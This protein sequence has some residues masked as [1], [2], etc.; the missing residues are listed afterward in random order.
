MCR[1]F[2]YVGKNVILKKILWDPENSILKQSYKM[3]YTPDIDDNTRNH[4][5]NVDG[6]GISWY[7]KDNFPYLYKSLKTPWSDVNMLEFTKCISSKFI[8]AHIRAIK[9]GNC[10]NYVNEYNCHPFRIDKFCWMHNGNISK[11]EKLLDYIMKN[12]DID[13]VQK[14]KGN[15]DSEYCFIIFLHYLK[16]NKSDYESVSFAKLQK[17]MIKTIQKI[18]ELV[19]D[20]ICS[21]NFCVTNKKIT[22]CTRYINSTEEPP[23]LYY[24]SEN[25]NIMISSEPI[26][27][28]KKWILLPKNSMITI[29][30]TKKILIDEVK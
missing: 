16:L 14:I 6:F 5:V 24:C 10:K 7:I 26:Y 21:L 1:F 11:K 4:L 30:K 2:V 29:T 12:A 13:L 20:D 27:K 15:T 28:N 19:E 23:S 22:I 25:N 8:Y 3:T 18:L 9:P 17:C